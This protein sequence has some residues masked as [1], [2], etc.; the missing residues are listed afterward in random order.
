MTSLTTLSVLFALCA[1]AR[2]PQVRRHSSPEGSLQTSSLEKIGRSLTKLTQEYPFYHSSEELRQEA[3]QLVAGCESAKIQSIE[4]G[5][6]SIDVVRVNSTSA[7]AINKVFILFGEH[8]RELISPETGLAL[9]RELCQQSSD[10]SKEVRKDSEFLLV[11]NGNPRLRP[12]VEA[13]NYCVRTNPKGVDLNRNWDEEWQQDSSSGGDTNPG[14]APFSEPETQILRSLV[15]KYKPT[16]YLSVHSGTLGLYMPWAFDQMHE[17]DRNQKAMMSILEELDEDHCKCPYGAAGK[18]V[19][20]SCP[21]TSLDWIYDRLQTPY[22]FAFEIF[23][24]KELMPMLKERW[25]KRKEQPVKSL[26]QRAQLSHARA[27]FKAHPSDF[28]QMSNTD[29]AESA[30]H[31]DSRSCIE[32]YNPTNEELFNSTVKNWVTA[33]LEMA[34][35]VSKRLQMDGKE[36]EEMSR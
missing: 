25:H 34:Q 23:V 1:S 20:Y 8:S 21:G 5:N 19:G 31:M 33:Y 26:L 10:L 4:Q 7:E 24:G 14:P 9:L 27:F 16:T 3:Q 28:V 32:L 22:A 35:K 17:A 15:S 6:V 18:E 13:G 12:E 11:L 29:R 2:N 36:P 30:D